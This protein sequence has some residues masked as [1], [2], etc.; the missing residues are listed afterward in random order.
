MLETPAELKVH[1]GISAISGWHCTSTDIEVLIDGKSI[2]KAGTGTMR[3]DT[4]GVCGH[5]D[6]G[7]SLLVNYGSYEPGLHKLTL[8][9][10]GEISDE[11]EFATARIAGDETDY[12]RG[13]MGTTVVDD[14][15]APGDRVYLSWVEEQQGFAA[16]RIDKSD[17]EAEIKTL[18]F[19]L[20][21]EYIGSQRVYDNDPNYHPEETITNVEFEFDTS[22]PDFVLRSPVP[23]FGHCTFT[24]D[25]Q[26]SGHRK[27][28]SVGDYICNDGQ[29]EGTYSLSLDIRSALHQHLQGI[30]QLYGNLGLDD[31]T[32][33]VDDRTIILS[34]LSE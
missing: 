10:D 2:G 3:E 16:Y 23:E 12:A 24:G 30:V 17:I 7:F 34:G 4:V 32:N 19:F 26:V 22:N 5:A 18:E 27:M 1:S 33:S 21:R 29:R 25:I 28:K 31:S 15:P 14:F 9:V 6:T 8:V 13:L 11:R 20:N